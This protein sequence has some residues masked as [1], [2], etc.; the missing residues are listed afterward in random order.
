MDL[1][2]VNQQLND[3]LNRWLQGVAAYFSD[4]SQRETYGWI[5]FGLGLL[6]AVVGLFLL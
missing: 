4:L 1:Q 6:L 2:Q 5:A 3:S